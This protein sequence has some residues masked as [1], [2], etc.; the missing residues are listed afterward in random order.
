MPESTDGTL[1][2]DESAFADFL[3]RMLTH[4]GSISAMAR[5]YNVDRANLDKAFRGKRPPSAALLSRMDA[6][7]KLVYEFSAVKS[8]SKQRG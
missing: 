1:R 4:F 6:T 5:H 2:L 7:K 8:D 3:R